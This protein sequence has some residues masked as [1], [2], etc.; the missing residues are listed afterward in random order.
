MVLPGGHSPHRGGRPDTVC[1]IAY[2]TSGI[3]SENEIPCPWL[4]AGP[5]KPIKK[6]DVDEYP[7]ALDHVGLLVNEP[8]STAGMLFS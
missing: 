4:P 2:A 1:T 3:G 7:E 5:G 8:S 6:A